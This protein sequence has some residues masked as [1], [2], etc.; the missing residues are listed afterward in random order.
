MLQLMHFWLPF[1]FF[2]ARLS[3]VRTT[4]FVE[5]R[6]KSLFLVESSSSRSSYDE[7]VVVYQ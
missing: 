5:T 1:Q 2:L 3:L 4:P 7:T 6:E